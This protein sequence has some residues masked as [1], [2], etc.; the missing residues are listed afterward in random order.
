MLDFL[1]ENRSNTIRLHYNDYRELLELCDSDV[2]LLFNTYGL[3]YISGDEENI[4]LFICDYVLF[5][6]FIKLDKFEMYPS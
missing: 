4:E 6:E 5:T 2:V 3:E 1:I